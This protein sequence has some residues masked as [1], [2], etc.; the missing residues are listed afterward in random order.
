MVRYEKCSGLEM[1]LQVL[2]LIKI[3][4][5]EL[6]SLFEIDFNVF[7][8]IFLLLICPQKESPQMWQCLYEPVADHEHLIQDLSIFS[9]E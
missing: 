5:S 6:F 7:D 2:S 1:L 3:Y 9:D 8:F 4:L